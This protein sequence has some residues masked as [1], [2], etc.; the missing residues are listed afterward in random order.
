MISI[1]ASLIPFIEHNDA[2]R[3]L[4][5][6][7]MLQQS[8]TIKG[9][10]N[11]IVETGMEKEILK[12]ST[13]SEISNKSGLINFSSKKKLRIIRNFIPRTLK[14]DNKS[15]YAKIKNKLKEKS[16]IPT[17]HYKK[18][19][20]I[21][22]N[23]TE[24]KSNQKIYNTKNFLKH[25]N[26]WIKKGEIIKNESENKKAKL[27]LG[28]N[29]LTAYICWDGYNFED[30]IILNETLKTND[31]LTSTYLKTY[32]TFIINNRIGRVRTKINL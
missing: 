26:E 23:E 17:E 31:R 10:E 25:K 29:L 16:T 8:I 6:A 7:S 15:I 20:K 13:I 30:A 21:L 19:R 5:G 4:M 28:K 2:N 3:A 32:K 9:R 11:A 12:N 1:G 14:I 24:N 18:E 27:K 22:L